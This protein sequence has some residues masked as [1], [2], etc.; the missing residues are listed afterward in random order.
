M[1]RLGFIGCGLMMQQHYERLARRDDI[2]FVGHCDI[3]R[4]AARQAA[5]TYGGDACTEPS[6][7]FDRCKPDAVYIAVPPFA[8]GAIEEEAIQRGIHLFIEKPIGLDLT[9]AKKIATLL[10]KSPVISSVGYCYRYAET[11]SQAKQLLRGKAI[12]HISASWIG[13]IPDAAWWS[14]REKSGGQLVEQCTHL[15]DTIR[16]VSGEVAE[17]YAVATRGCIGCKDNYDLDDSS[18]VSMRMKNGATAAIVSTCAVDHGHRVE[19]EFITPNLTVRLNR[20]NLQVL[21]SSKSYEYYCENDMFTDESATFIHA[22]AT[23]NRKSIKSSYADALKTLNVTLAAN[24]SIN[25]G[26]P[27]KV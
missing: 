16:Y 8:H 22:V 23:S 3:D 7:L 21:E 15:F 6:V 1:I 24:A 27:V 13:G 25:S 2:A 19:I 5:E 11:V 17:V 4:D 20:T 9:Q 12:C 18:V 14:L 26:M 10:R